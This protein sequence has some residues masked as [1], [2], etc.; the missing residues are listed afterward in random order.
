MRYVGRDDVKVLRDIDLQNEFNKRSND[1]Y[2][3]EV[4][5]IQTCI[6]AQ[7][8]CGDPIICKF[9]AKVDELNP[10]QEI[11]YDYYKEMPS[12][13]DLLA[14]GNDAAYVEKQCLKMAYYI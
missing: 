10:D 8:G 12:D 7:V 11:R 13:E 14:V 3:N 6:K 9:M 5:V 4:E 2:W 1:P